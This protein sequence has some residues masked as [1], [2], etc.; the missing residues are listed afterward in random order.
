MPFGRSALLLGLL[1]LTWAGGLSQELSFKF[2]APF[3][4]PDLDV[5]WKAVSA[6]PT[7]A[8]VYKLLP[9]HYAA[10]GVSNL[11]VLGQFTQ[12]QKTKDNTDWLVYNTPDDSRRLGLFF[13]LGS[14]EFQLR[15]SH[16]PKQ[17]VEAVPSEA[18]A[19]RLTTNWLIKLGINIQ[20]VERKN[21]SADPNLIC[22]ASQTLY[23]TNHSMITNIE[24][25]GVRF[26]R[27][28]D[29]SS[30]VGNGT[31][32][33]GEL[34][35]GDHGKL[36]DMS[37]SWRNLK[38]HKEYATADPQTI[39]KWV[40]S[41][42]AVQGMMP[43]NSSPINWKRVKSLTITRVELCYYAGGP[44]EPSEW[45]MPFAALW[46]TVDTGDRKLEVEVDCPVIDKSKRIPN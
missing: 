22:F 40:R 45:L 25:R 12:E 13:P 32:G 28:I 15:E 42:Q 19:L 11:I 21:D 1:Q 36:N 20:D 44:F 37:I 5:R 6:L 31:G 35:F 27:S 26:R 8:W 23:F 3:R 2:G 14:L 17:L 16:G 46:T 18:E 33:N 38:R 24:F 30:F 4:S 43:M 34:H 39:I 10:E 7:R 9:N 41:G 29:G